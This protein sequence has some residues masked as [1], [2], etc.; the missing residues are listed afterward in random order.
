MEQETCT[1]K[2]STTLKTMEI[3]FKV[4]ILETGKPTQKIGPLSFIMVHF[5]DFNILIGF[6]QVGVECDDVT[7]DGR[8]VTFH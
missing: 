1:I 8:E 4:T 7:P 6:L 3:K 2:Q 5:K